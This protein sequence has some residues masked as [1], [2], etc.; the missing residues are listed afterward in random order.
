MC[1]VHRQI[2]IGGRD[3]EGVERR[4]G[5][6]E[7]A[8]GGRDRGV[9]EVRDLG[10][11]PAQDVPQDEHRA[12]AGWQV[13]QRG[14]E[15]EANGLT[16][17]GKVGRVAALGEDPGVRH[18]LDPRV[19]GK[20]HAQ[21]GTGVRRGTEVHRAGA[22]LGTAEHVETDVGRDGEQP[23]AQ[24]CAALVVAVEVPPG[25]HQR[26]LYGVLGLERRAEHP[27][28]V[29]DQVVAVA[30]EPGT[31][32]RT[33]ARPLPP[34][35]VRGVSRAGL[36]DRVHASDDRRPPMTRAR[37]GGGWSFA[38]PGPLSWEHRTR[39]QSS[40][41][42]GRSRS[43]RTSSS[44]SSSTSSIGVMT[45]TTGSPP[46]ALPGPPSRPRRRRRAARRRAVPRWW[47]RG[48]WVRGRWSGVGGSGV[49]GSGVGGSGVGGVRVGRSGVGGSGVGGSGVGGS[50]VGGSGVGGS[51]VGGSGVG[52]SGV[53]GSGVGGSGVG[54]SGVGGS[55]V[56][57]SGVRGSGVGRS[58]VGRARDAGPGG[59]GRWQPRS[60]CRRPVRQR[61][62]RSPTRRAPG[63]RPEW[64]PVRS[65]RTEADQAHVGRD[66]HR[67]RGTATLGGREIPCPLRG[68][69]LGVL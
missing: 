45:S 66:Q 52:G 38:A 28:A 44:T 63:Y 2:R 69:R 11:R 32:V 58:G 62:R 65:E 42:R 33:L 34:A 49:G 67:A 60:R 47:V 46:R 16:L 56:G 68:R 55:G 64:S 31:D 35:G 14:D 6:L 29:A 20:R 39:R 57:G 22:A 43:V 24:G 9:Q 40:P 48:P 41:P 53:G 13:L 61:S 26:F 59:F 23:R 10:R 30:F 15:R 1:V 25:P 18:G 5:P 50:G 37:C 54:G 12:L 27:V 3:V 51:G 8:V 7:S 36:L 17:R 21:C 4:A 19:L